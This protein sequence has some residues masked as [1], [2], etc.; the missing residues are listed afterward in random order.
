M[1]LGAKD[2]SSLTSDYYD[3]DDT[4]LNRI[5]PQTL[6]TKTW[7]YREHRSSFG[8]NGSTK[9]FMACSTSPI[10]SAQNRRN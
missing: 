9:C 3:Q 2:F 8:N 6:A 4:E 1:A 5:Y 7:H 10:E